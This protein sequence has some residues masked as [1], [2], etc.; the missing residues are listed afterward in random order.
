[1]KSQFIALTLLA[2]ATPAIASINATETPPLD[3]TPQPAAFISEP[4]ARLN[5]DCGAPREMLY[6]LRDASGA[7]VG[8]GVAQ[9]TPPC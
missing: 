6:I 9:A 2:T 1:M 5:T 4:V 8:M 7:I 3:M